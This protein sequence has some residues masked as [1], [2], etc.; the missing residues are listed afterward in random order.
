LILEQPIMKRLVATLALAL[1]T[2][3]APAFAQQ[4]GGVRVEFQ[5][6]G[7][8][9]YGAYGRVSALHAA[10]RAV[11]LIQ[12]ALP[13]GS[14]QITNLTGGNS[15]N[16]IA[17]DGLIELKLTAGSAKAYEAL[18]AAVTKA[19]A[20]GAAAENAFRGVKAGDLTAGA[21]ATVR[22]SVTRF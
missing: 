5:G 3:G 17:S 6:P 19:A 21:P 2:V 22:S 9:S 1:A 13:A 10:A 18:V 8:H 14:Y 20:D 15:V 7:G 16:A 12:K 4:S 11:I